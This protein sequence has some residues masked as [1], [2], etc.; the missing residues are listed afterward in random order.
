MV[1][2]LL[3]KGLETRTRE[4]LNKTPDVD[5]TYRVSE[6]V[7]DFRD[8]SKKGEC[9]IPCKYY[10]KIYTRWAATGGTDDIVKFQR[11][12]NNPKK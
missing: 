7:A 11:F 3:L 10:V 12:C 2:T 8:S 4:C 6:S 1:K 5:C 9:E